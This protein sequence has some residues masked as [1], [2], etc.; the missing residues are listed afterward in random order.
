MS[1]FSSS[2]NL[3]RLSFKIHCHL[4]SKIYEHQ[5]TL[6]KILAHRRARRSLIL[7]KQKIVLFQ[8]EPFFPVLYHLT[9]SFHSFTVV[10]TIPR[11]TSEYTRLFAFPLPFIACLL[12]KLHA[13][14]DFLLSCLSC[15]KGQIFMFIFIYSLGVF[16]LST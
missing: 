14:I 15:R 8:E 2:L 4:S 9:F 1:R 11:I 12:I 3:E 6:D 7:H 10:V 13:D 16:I 5:P